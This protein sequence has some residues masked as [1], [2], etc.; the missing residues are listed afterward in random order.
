[1]HDEKQVYMH[2][3]NLHEMALMYI[4]TYIYTYIYIYIYLNLLECTKT[5]HAHARE[6]RNCVNMRWLQSAHVHL[7]A[8]LHHRVQDMVQEIWSII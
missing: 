2:E 4:Y 7:Q 3:N 6:H 8:Y 1:M 5:W